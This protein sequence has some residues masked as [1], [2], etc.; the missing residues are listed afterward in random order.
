MGHD[1]SG[2]GIRLPL[3]KYDLIESVAMRGYGTR[4]NDL[5]FSLKSNSNFRINK[6]K[7][8]NKC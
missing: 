2:D 7:F 8:L 6:K 5:P 1:A 4:P 3:S